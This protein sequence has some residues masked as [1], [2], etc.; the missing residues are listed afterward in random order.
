MRKGEKPTSGW[1]YLF[2]MQNI[3][4]QQKETRDHVQSTLTNLFDNRRLRIASTDPY[5]P[6]VI[7]FLLFFLSVFILFFSFLVGTKNMY[8]HAFICA[9]L[10]LPLCLTITTVAAM[11]YPYSTRL[12]QSDAP[13][14]LSLESNFI[15]LFFFGPTVVQQKKNMEE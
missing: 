4:N 14:G 13:L 12:V 11:D 8:T 10:A 3:L 6:S 7:Y 9:C 1:T 15:F 5:L 2:R